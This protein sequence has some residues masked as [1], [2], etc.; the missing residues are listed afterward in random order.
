MPRIIL[1]AA[2]SENGIIGSDGK[3]PWHITEDLRRFKRITTGFPCIMGRKTYQSLEKPLPN[4]QNIVL[5]RDVAFIESKLPAGVFVVSTWLDAVKLGE[6]FSDEIYVIGG[7][8]VYE[9]FLPVAS[10]IDIT[11]ILSRFVGDT[12]F[13]DLPE[14]WRAQIGEWRDTVDQLE[15]GKS[16]RYRYETYY[17]KHSPYLQPMADDVEAS[18][19]LNVREIECVRSWRLDPDSVAP[20]FT[21][22]EE[23]DFRKKLERLGLDHEAILG[24]EYKV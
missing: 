15:N 16:V 4:R 10:R 24:L 8:Q 14:C 17:P 6:S 3:I 9:Q 22:A 7:G 18:L 19:V 23:V 1:I 12:F 5:S 11:R 21:K 2:V 20:K 13:P